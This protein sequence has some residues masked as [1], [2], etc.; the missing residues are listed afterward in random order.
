MKLHEITDD[1]PLLARVMKQHL[2]KGGT[3]IYNRVDDEYPEDHWHHKVRYTAVSVGRIIDD[4]TDGDGN[5]TRTVIE[6][7]SAAGRTLH[8]SVPDEL[9]HLWSLHKVAD[10]T[11]EWYRV[12]K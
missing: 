3:I 8:T 9:A 6:W 10:N 12:A 7:R 4:P 5:G 2:A 11:W 1:E